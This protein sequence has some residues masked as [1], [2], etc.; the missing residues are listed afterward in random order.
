MN[1]QDRLSNANPFKRVLYII[2]LKARQT[3]FFGRARFFRYK[4]DRDNVVRSVEKSFLFKI[5]AEQTG[6]ASN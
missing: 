2:P 3:D 1:C 5:T 6:Y 4:F